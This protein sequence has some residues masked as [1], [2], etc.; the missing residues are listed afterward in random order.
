MSEKGLACTLN[1]ITVVCIMN[2]HYTRL[3]IEEDRLNVSTATDI[4]RPTEDDSL[5]AIPNVF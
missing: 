3:Q 2:H 4:T 1:Y 5:R